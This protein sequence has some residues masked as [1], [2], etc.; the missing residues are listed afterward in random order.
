MCPQCRQTV[1]AWAQ[2]CP[3]CRYRFPGAPPQGAGQ[4]PGATPTGTP[5][6]V[7]PSASCQ[8]GQPE[9]PHERVL[10]EARGV[11]G[12]I[13]LLA[14][15]VRIKRQGWRAL[16]SQ[17]LKGD[18]EILVDRIT[19]IQFRMPGIVINGYIQF[20]FEGG[21]ETKKGVWDATRDENSVFESAQ[22]DFAALLPATSV[23]GRPRLCCPRPRSP[24][25][26]AAMRRTPTRPPTRHR[27]R[28]FADRPGIPH[29]SLPPEPDIAATAS[30]GGRSPLYSSFWRARPGS[31]C[32]DGPPADR[33][34][35]PRAGRRQGAHQ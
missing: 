26:V 34:S 3:E 22:A 18:K 12:Q 9:S 4:R 33:P 28:A 2:D 20:A 31:R 23:A 13:E 8:G 14:D 15:R 24:G 19:S 1:P 6:G 27:R 30:P 7:Q 25:G 10:M 5:L 17:G 32:A 11:N 21:H 16:L 29:M 35:V